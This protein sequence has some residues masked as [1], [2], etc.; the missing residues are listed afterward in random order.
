MTGAGLYLAHISVHGRIRSEA[1]ELGCDADTGGQ[2][3]YVLDLVSH[4]ASVH[5]IAR[6]D[7]F[8]RCITDGRISTDYARE[9]EPITATTQIIRIR[10]G[11]ASYIPKE[12]LWPNLPEFIDNTIA[13]M[14]QQD[15]LPD[16]L[17]GHYADAGLVASRISKVLGIPFL[18]TAHSLGRYKRQRLLT[19]GHD[20]RELEKRYHFVT[21]IEAEEEALENA[22]GVIASTHHEVNEQYSA[23]DH[24]VP[25]SMSVIPPGSDF[26]GM[27]L[28]PSWTSLRKLKESLSPFLREPGKPPVL[29]IARPDRQKNI[30]GLINAFGSSALREKANLVL[31][32]G[33]REDV[34]NMDAEQGQLFADVFSLIDR[35]DLYGSVAYPKRHEREDVATMLH[36]ARLNRGVLANVSSHENFGLTLIEAAATGVPVV[37]SGAGGMSEVIASCKHGLIADGEDPADIAEKLDAILSKRNLWRALS[38]LG[39]ERSYASYSWAAFA[40]RYVQMVRRVLQNRMQI[41]AIQDKV[42]MVARHKKVFLCDI[43]DTL[44]GDAAA[45]ARLASILRRHPEIAFGVATGRSLAGAMEVLKDQGLPVP[46]IFITSVGSRI[47]YNFDGLLED[48]DWTSHIRFAWQPQSIRKLVERQH[49]LFLQEPDAQGPE[50]ISYYVRGQRKDA[51]ADLKSLLRRNRL[52]AR[53]ILARNQC[54]D[55]LPTRCSKGHALRYLSWRLGVDVS[56]F[57]TAGD[58]GNDLDMLA[59]STNSIVVANHMAELDVLKG[60][61]SVYFS[62]LR[63]T[64]GVIDGL[65]H[66]GV[67]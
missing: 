58:S 47:H 32:M 12:E 48:L 66:F 39:R 67:S 27:S 25:E 4:L 7:L 51:A 59:G 2:T 9:R 45:Q 11:P 57:I 46:D 16:I 20:A 6:I 33:C 50:K 36:F 30:E 8:T 28:R 3:K 53:V 1:P 41:P 61:P 21:R 22:A 65:R 37:S 55:I 10:C 52:K 23:Y 29:A 18:F 64:A 62:K 34:A 17:H 38:R 31:L 35:H 5:G 19:A 42:R 49:W 54:L 43:D 15:R 24:F 14:R 26:V 60:Q 56:R 13:Y 44:L 40:D 63:A